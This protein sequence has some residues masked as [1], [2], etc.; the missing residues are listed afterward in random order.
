[1]F[2]H[3]S[4]EWLH[5]EVELRRKKLCAAPPVLLILSAHRSLEAFHF[6]FAV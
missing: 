6:L 4:G 3:I 1:M 2:A 5:H